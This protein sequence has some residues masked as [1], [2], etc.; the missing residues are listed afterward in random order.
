MSDLDIIKRLAKGFGISL[1]QVKELSWDTKGY[2]LNENDQVTALNL[3]NASI[4]E[5][6]KL[7]VLLSGLTS[8]K[9]LWL[10]HNEV[11]ELGPLSGFTSL[12]ELS[13][14]SNIISDLSTLS[15]L[16]SLHTLS[17]SVNQII[18]I[19]PISELKA[20]RRLW[21][22]GNQIKDLRPLKNLPV[23]QRLRLDRNQIRDLRPLSELTSLKM[24]RLDVNLL[25]D[26]EP[27]CKLQQLSTLGLTNNPLKKLP[28]WI[29]DFFMEIE[30]SK[31]GGNGITFFD[32]PLESPPPEIIR[33]GKEAVKVYFRQLNE[34]DRDYL[35]EAK[36]LIVGEPGAGKTSMA[37]KLKN[38]ECELPKEDKT[39]RGIDVLN[40]EFPVEP[41][42]FPQIADNRKV[43]KRYFRVN[44]WDFGGQE[45]YKATHRFFLT[46]R[47]LYALV[48]DNRMEDT[49]FNYWLHVVEMFGGDSPLLIVQNEKQERKRELDVTAMRARF[50]N[51]R[52]DVIRVNFADK[53]R[54]RLQELKLEIRKLITK[55]PH[56][57]SQVPSKWTKIRRELEYE[58][59]HTISPTDY[60]ELCAVH[61]IHGK[62]DALVLAQYFHDIGVFLH[63]QDDPLL[64][65]TIFLD[66]NWATNAVYQILDHPLLDGQQGRFNMADAESIWR[67]DEYQFLRYELLRLMNKFFLAYEIDDSGHYIVPDKLPG[68]KPDYEWDEDHNLCMKYDYDLFMP[69]GIMSQFIVEMHRFIIAHDKVWK[70]GALFEREGAT[71][72]VVE[73]Y[74]ARNIKIR[75]SG[76]NKRDFMTIIVDRLDSINAQYEKMKVEKLILCICDECKESKN[77]YPYKYSDLK[78]RI[79]KGRR[80]VECG[81]SYEMVNVRQ[82]IDDVL[83]EN[84][85]KDEMRDRVVRL[86]NNIF[87]SYSH[88]DEVFLDSLKTH[89][90]VMN[91]EGLNVDL[92]DDNRISSGD[93][94]KEEIRKALETAGIAIILLSTKF[95][96]SKF[97]REYEL[98]K[99][100]QAA[101]K[102]GTVILPLIVS[103]CRFE[104]SPLSAFQTVNSPNNPL[105]ELSE[106]AREREYLKLMDRIE[107]L[108]GN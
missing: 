28:H 37:W 32:N 26:L 81:K 31:Y 23:L 57:G 95:L 64:S 74:D 66:A 90:E 42:D 102:N 103:P 34:Q 70:R 101:K 54:F 4:K 73:S 22:S 47:S 24:L 88:K 79:E 56:I 75:I 59:R 98:P 105:S 96:A 8:L 38:P 99:L 16:N 97:I 58:I 83:N 36:L 1:K 65:K 82:L 14:S 78:R 44:I 53:N 100:L 3:N 93:L 69:K 62:K 17:L 67:G 72:E 19:G 52:N 30:W 29:T 45:I 10:D 77:P 15:N 61:G 63:F 55:L 49:D 108:V 104:K 41:K 80:E 60:F 76:K 43:K 107:E 40:F 35:F 12:Q 13:L 2:V 20:L 51:I 18:D 9:R 85:P 50:K 33:Q 27:L 68:R 89:I 7:T 25:T 106:T 11:S 92:W 39:T 46:N 86:K 84:M 87:V 21:L 91:Y 5:L 71:A 48:A 94:W 6:K